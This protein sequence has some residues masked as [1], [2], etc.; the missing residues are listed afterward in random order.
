MSGKQR[1][2]GQRHPTPTYLCCNADTPADARNSGLHSC[3]RQSSSAAV[4]ANTAKIEL[5]RT[6]VQAVPQPTTPGGCPGKGGGQ[7]GPPCTPTSAGIHYSLHVG[8]Y[9]VAGAAATAASA[10]AASASSNATAAATT[11]RRDGTARGTDP[12]SAGLPGG[13]AL[14]TLLSPGVV[15]VAAAAR[16]QRAGGY[17]GRRDRPVTRV[18]AAWV[19]GPQPSGCQRTCRNASRLGWAPSG[20]HR[21]RGPCPCPWGARPRGRGPWRRQEAGWAARSSPLG[22]EGGER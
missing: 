16:G 2:G 15:V 5:L 10:T 8:A 12:A 6:H 13:F 11:H 1:E 9:P 19:Q 20:P 7:T 22:G 14:V 17:Q 21:G 18:A 4:V 3:W